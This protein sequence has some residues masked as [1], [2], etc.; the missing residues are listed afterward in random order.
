MHLAIRKQWSKAWDVDSDLE[1]HFDSA[2]Y[3]SYVLKLHNSLIKPWLSS[4]KMGIIPI[5]E[6]FIRM[7]KILYIKQLTKYLTYSK[8]SRNESCHYSSSSCCCYQGLY[9]SVASFRGI[10]DTRIPVLV[11]P[12]TVLCNFLWSIDPKIL[13]IWGLVTKQIKNYF[14]Q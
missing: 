14:T 4:L 3:W 11:G 5:A 8:C 7:S 9:L 2:V 1:P 10:V 6:V 13:L 12:E